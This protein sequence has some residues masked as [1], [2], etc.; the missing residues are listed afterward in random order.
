MKKS[1]M[2]VV[3]TF[4]ALL[5]GTAFG[6]AADNP[7]LRIMPLGDSITHGSQSVR[8]NG[9][10]APLY[11]AL[12]NLGYNVDYVGTQTDNYS[13]DD[14]FLA[15][16]DH[17]GHSGW[18]IEN[19]S[20]GIYDFI[21]EF[22]SQI[23]DPHVILLHIGTNDTGDGEPAFRSEATN[24]LVRLLD[25]IHE[26]QPSAKVVVT[27]LMRRYTTAGDLTNNWKYA[28]ITNVFNP[29][30]PG[31]VADQQAKGQAAYFLDMHAAVSDWDQIAD[32]VHP[33][34]VGY[35]NM[36]NA[37][38]SAVTSIV[39]DPANFA[40]ENDLAVV[41]ATMEI[42]GED[43][44][45]INF[46]FNQKVTA[47]TATNAA[48]W[49]VSGTEAV[50]TITLSADQ[51]T[52]TLAFP[53]GEYYSPVT[54]TAKQGGVRNATGGKALYAD[55][56]LTIPGV[57]PQGAYRYVP[58]EE[59]NS[60][61]LVYDLDIPIKGD[62]AH[63]PVP[64]NVDDA[65]KIGAFSRVAYYME[66]QKAGEPMQYVWVSMD[67]FTNDAARVGVPAGWQF[68]KD[69]TN[70]RVWSNVPNIRTNET[71]AVGNIEFWPVSFEGTV[72]RG[73]E[74]ALAVY[75]MDDKPTSGEYGSMQVHDTARTTNSCIFTY[76]RFQKNDATE[77]GIGPHYNA[78]NK[79][80]DWTQTYNAGQYSLR[81]FQVYVLP[82]TSS[83]VAPE[84]VSA[85]P[86]FGNDGPMV[87][88]RFSADVLLDGLD[89]AFSVSSG[90]VTSVE[91]DG[92]DFSL[93][94]VHVAGVAS[95]SFNLSVD[96]ARVK[97]AANGATPMASGT[98]LTLARPL[99]AGVVEHVPAELRAGY[100]PIYALND[101]DRAKHKVNWRDGVPYDFDDTARF[102]WRVDRVAYY[103]EIVSLDGSV[104][105]FAWTSFDSWTDDPALLG[106]PV[107]DAIA[108]G[109]RWVANQDVF[110][111]VDGIVNG[112][113]M[114]GGFLEF[115]PHN[116]GG[117]NPSNIPF[118]SGSTCDWGD[119]LGTTG[120][121]SCMQVHNVTNRQTILALDNFN[122]NN[123]SGVCAG[124]G[125]NT[126]YPANDKAGGTINPDWTQ[127]YAP[128]R[129]YSRITLHVLV[130]PKAGTRLPAN[131]AAN[132]PQAKDYTLLYQIDVPTPFNSH[133]A[134][135]YA[136]AHT[137]DNRARYAGRARGLLPGAHDDQREP[138]D[139]LVLGG[140]RRLHGR[141]CLLLV[142]HERQH[143][144]VR[145]EPRRCL[146]RER[147][148]AGPVRGRQHRVLLLVVRQGQQPQHRREHGPVRLRRLAEFR[149]GRRLQ[150][151]ADPQLQR[152]ADAD[153]H[154]PAPP[155]R[156]Q[157][158]HR[159]RQLLD[160]GQP[161]LDADVQGPPVRRA[162]P[163]RVRGVRDDAVR[164]LP[165]RREPGPDEGERGVRRDRA[166]AAARP[167]G[168]DV[169]VGQRGRGR[170]RRVPGRSARG[171]ADARRAACRLREL[172][173][174]VR[175]HV[176]R[177][178]EDGEQV[179]H[180]RRR[181]PASRVPHGGG[182]AGSRELR[183]RVPAEHPA[184]DVQLHVEGRAVCGGRVALREHGLRP[185]G[186]PAASRRRGR[187][188][189]VGVGVDGRLH[190]R[191]LED[192]LA[193]EA[194]RQRLPGIRDEP[195][196]ARVEVGQR[197][198]RDARRVLG[199]Q[200]RVL[201]ARL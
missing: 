59:F 28:A 115:W 126:Q 187:L 74:G 125:N 99:P 9:Y 36:A 130:K 14:P 26:C 3:A 87:D 170:R 16:S 143:Q 8:G 129:T 109:Q 106:V 158:G 51:R 156:R 132:V 165:R 195:L 23:D 82:E 46:T 139:H 175:L 151:P 174:P 63:K 32:T 53:S 142:R 39:P 13:K 78:N 147:R 183:A 190:G 136:A 188:G 71:I 73:L 197:S 80:W 134:E 149:D 144:A 108:C 111:N 69:V 11:V 184:H 24:R 104:T 103:M 102:P 180:D 93:V 10:R 57:F 77:L 47:A 15:D 98:T 76:N 55:A 193:D 83:A 191:S 43:A 155:F 97:A 58:P 181:R 94:H 161:G 146:Q 5:A 119:S 198:P 171:G 40:T 75:D 101:I 179:L 100:V 48:N 194:P 163:L 201:L 38:V 107:N 12:T 172:H 1:F 114:D 52:A 173:A 105:N 196:R 110:S 140:V 84:I 135:Q 124:L 166:A 68:L 153:L 168:V 178:G 72:T 185:R 96:G 189:A 123:D 157:H 2:Y 56:A 167:L 4:A 150:L 133:N 145:L 89:A 64:Y 131:V 90:Y 182:R 121:Y 49:T 116:Y 152:I 86:T 91:R 29:A 66:L 6:A 37:W 141:P 138:H 22:F 199:R 200:H 162:P 41:Q 79:G 67:A 117:A 34:D 50:P 42:V 160:G 154:Q 85:T 192:R 88:V 31:I 177:R 113:G 159:H 45:A 44:F 7:V 17:E 169:H 95:D 62:F 21:P 61:R 137:V 112:T 128:T 70:L 118:A 122:G 35:T 164:D 127:A 27:T 176:R 30:I 18:K 25:R 65:G 20:N 33:N 120:W 60:Y 148:E 19:A 92:N 54:V 81:H 186:L